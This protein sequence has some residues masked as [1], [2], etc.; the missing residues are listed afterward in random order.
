LTWTPAN[1]SALN[2]PAGGQAWRRRARDTL[3]R[4]RSLLEGALGS[5][6][7]RGLARGGVQPPSKAE[8]HPRGRPAPE[9]GET[10]P[11]GATGP[12]ARRGCTGTA[13]YPSSGAEFRPR[14]ARPTIWWVVGPWVCF[15]HVFRFVCVCFLRMQAGFPW[16]FRGPLW[17][18]PTL[19]GKRFSITLSEFAM[20]FKLR[21]ATTTN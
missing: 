17:L 4:D 9:R 16:L 3:E 6:L 7:R 18:S 13:S 1:V 10:S 12:R 8:L 19:G 15:A 5:R 2:A 11:E 14:V 20:L 21:G